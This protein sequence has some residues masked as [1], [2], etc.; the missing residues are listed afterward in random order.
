MARLTVD[1]FATQLK[2]ALGSHL[3]TLLL[4]GSAA[5]HPAE[6]ADALNTLLIVSPDHGSLDSELFV[7]LAEPVRRWVAAGHPPPLIMTD[8]EWRSSAD[9]FPIEYEDI[10]E[11]H[12]I[13]A[14]RDPWSGINV[15]REHVR[16]QLEHE[17]MGKL[18]HLRQAFA[19]YWNNPKRLAEIVRETRSSFL[20][21]LRAAL[22]LSGRKAPATA[23]A[24]VRDAAGLVGFAAAGLTEPTAYLDAVTRTADYVNRLERN[25][26]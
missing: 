19:A 3:W 23:D 11:A 9:A 1:A 15:R 16:R 24:L 12:R 14:G 2:D 20:T 5:R 6:Q 25:P 18:M 21:M 13:L 22:R 17:L 8:R 7:R 10:R 26:S 4:Y